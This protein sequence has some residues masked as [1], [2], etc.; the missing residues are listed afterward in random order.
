MQVQKDKII[1]THYKAIGWQT[2]IKETL[3]TI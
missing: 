3:E 1:A 2:I